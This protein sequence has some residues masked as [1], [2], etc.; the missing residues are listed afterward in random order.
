MLIFDSEY[1]S[2]AVED[3]HIYNKRRIE[4]TRI[5]RHHFQ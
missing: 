2:I 1:L 3:R 5:D 4:E